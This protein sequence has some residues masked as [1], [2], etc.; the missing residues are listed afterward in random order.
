[1]ASPSEREILAALGAVVD[2]D[3]GMGIVELG[4]VS[5]LQSRDGHVAFTRTLAVRMYRGQNP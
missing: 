4:M 3:K 1:M 5:G 2:P